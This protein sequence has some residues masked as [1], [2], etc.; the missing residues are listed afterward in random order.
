M[1]A[2]TDLEREARAM[3]ES[4][5]FKGVAEL[6]KALGWRYFHIPATAYKNHGIR[7][8]FPDITAVRGRWLLFIELKREKEH[9]SLE[10]LEWQA[11][12][13]RVQD[14]LKRM[15]GPSYE[16]VR[17]LVWRPSDLLSGEIAKILAGG[18]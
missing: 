8:G 12:L 5:L 4:D 13:H 18:Q 7:S 3:S 14:G 2:A 9:L 10:Q 11:D 17:H 1:P 15:A 16:A 6:L